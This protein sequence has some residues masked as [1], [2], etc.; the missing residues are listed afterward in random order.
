MFADTARVTNVHIIIIIKIA[1]WAPS[2]NFVGLYLATK[3]CIDNRKKNLFS[4]FFCPVR[5]VGSTPPLIHL[6]I[7]ALCILFAC[8]HCICFPTSFFL[9]YPLSYL[10]FPLRIDP[11]RFQ[12]GGRNWRLNLGVLVV[13]V[14]CVCALLA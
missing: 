6:L 7:S 4:K 9:T 11:L 1:I 13:V 10:S 3:T 8:L 2:H 14:F 12:E 5:A